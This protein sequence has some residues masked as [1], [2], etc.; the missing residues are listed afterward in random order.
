MYQALLAD[1]CFCLL[2]YRG[3]RHR[4][5]SGVGSWGCSPYILGFGQETAVSSLDLCLL[6]WGARR[7]HVHTHTY[8]YIYYYIAC[9]LPAYHIIYIYIYMH[10]CRYTYIYIYIYI[11]KFVC[12]CLHDI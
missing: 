5:F 12:A 3:F 1:L 8:I 7:R 4:G 10:I 9:V 11:Y 2:H 6:G